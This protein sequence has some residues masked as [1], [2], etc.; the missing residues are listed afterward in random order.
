MWASGASAANNAGLGPNVARAAKKRVDIITDNRDYRDANSARYVIF[1][2][3]HHHGAQALRLAHPRR[4]HASALR[5]IAGLRTGSPRPRTAHSE[6]NQ[7]VP[8]M[9]SSLWA[10]TAGAKIPI[11]PVENSPTL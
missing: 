9:M 4:M 10:V 7:T 3:Q 8:S 11:V 1:I 2:E 5:S 6:P